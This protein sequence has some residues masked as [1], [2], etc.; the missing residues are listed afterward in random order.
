MFLAVSN[1]FR[2]DVNITT[3]RGYFCDGT[4]TNAVLEVP[5]QK[6]AT[7]NGVPEPS[8]PGISTTNPHL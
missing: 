4:R 5:P 1:S 8:F 2:E 3:L 7:R 6:D